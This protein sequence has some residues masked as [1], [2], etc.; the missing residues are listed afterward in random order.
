MAAAGVTY[1]MLL[2]VFPGIA[3]LIWLVQW[4]ADPDQA[5][6][7]VE[8]LSGVLPDS[9]VW[10]IEGEMSHRSDQASRSAGG[11]GLGSVLGLSVLL[12]SANS[13]MRGL[14]NAL[15]MIYDVDERRGFL[16]FT[17]VTLGFTV[18]IILFLVVSLGAILFLPAMLGALGTAVAFLIW[19]W[20]STLIVLAGAEF[21]AGLEGGRR[22]RRARMQGRRRPQAPPV[23]ADR[24]AIL[25]RT[26]NVPARSAGA[27]SWS[28]RM[29]IHHLATALLLIAGLAPA[30]VPA[31][32]G[33]KQF[34]VCPSQAKAEQ[35]VQSQGKFMPE[36][37]RTATV[38]EID[39]SAGPI[40][41]LDLSQQ[42]GIVGKIE[43]LAETTQWWT[44][45][46]NL[47]AP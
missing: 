25:G 30:A 44:A 43:S 1:Y 46:A 39:S 29:R 42:Q 34:P 21:D 5:G 13:G 4:F 7:L 32:S 2:A 6:R 27:R 36:G 45:C 12:W 41:V 40:C 11:F 9:A 35:I 18:G 37:C 3:V 16:R 10:M 19:I 20:R 38:T 23:G 26:L 28:M 24:A 14:F 8:A 22:G 47:R 17:A 31:A 15:N 33:P